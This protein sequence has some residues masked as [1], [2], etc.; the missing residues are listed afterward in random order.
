MYGT[1]LPQSPIGAG[2]SLILS[3]FNTRAPE[4]IVLSL[5]LRL[6]LLALAVLLPALVAALWVV[7]RAYDSERESMQRGLRET[8]RALSLVIDRELG[9]RETVARLHTSTVRRT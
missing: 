5:R 4:G 6:I 8:T 3:A 1:S 2:G 9:R 7:S